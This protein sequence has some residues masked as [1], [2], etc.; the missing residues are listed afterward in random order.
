MRTTTLFKSGG[1]V[2]VLALV[3]NDP[4]QLEAQPPADSA[5]DAFPALIWVKGGRFQMGCT[6]EQQN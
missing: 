1:W 4:G 2:L 5:R 6:S 3:L